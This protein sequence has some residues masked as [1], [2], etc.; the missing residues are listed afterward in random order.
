M[1][2]GGRLR[3]HRSRRWHEG[4]S[5]HGSEGT[6]Q[7]KYDQLLVPRRGGLRSETLRVAGALAK[8]ERFNF[9]PLRLLREFSRPLC[10]RRWEKYP[11]RAQS[12]LSSTL[13]ILNTSKPI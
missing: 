3:S 13:L 12:L 8:P 4:Y 1:Q 7:K 9:A 6:F 10:A 11:R 5:W 2:P